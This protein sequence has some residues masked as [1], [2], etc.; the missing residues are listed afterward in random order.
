MFDFYYGIAEPF[1]YYH[2][3]RAGIYNG[4]CHSKTYGV[5]E[6]ARKLFKIFFLFSEKKKYLFAF[7]QGVIDGFNWYSEKDS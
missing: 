2:Q 4:L 5:K 1:R 3:A 7:R 6:L